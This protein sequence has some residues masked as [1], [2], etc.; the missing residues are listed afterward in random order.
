MHKIRPIS[1]IY[2]KEFYQNSNKIKKAR[3]FGDLCIFTKT[4]APQHYLKIFQTILSNQTDDMITC[5][6]AEDD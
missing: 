6:L 4:S 1:T 5:V 2:L 3:N